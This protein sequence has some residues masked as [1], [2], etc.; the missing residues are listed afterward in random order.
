[1][2]NLC[3]HSFREQTGIIL[4]RSVEA[5]LIAL[6]GD[7]LSAKQSGPFHIHLSF[8]SDSVLLSILKFVLRSL[9]FLQ[10]CSD[11][12]RA[13]VGIGTEAPSVEVHS[14]SCWKISAR[15]EKQQSLIQLIRAI[16]NTHF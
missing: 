13:T 16:S 14:E 8:T 9:A 3:L 12:L 1:M 10:L 11:W 2:C 4:L 15:W 6:C 7:T 5:A